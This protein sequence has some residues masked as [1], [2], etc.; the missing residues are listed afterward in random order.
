MHTV[1]LGCEKQLS[2]A[3]SWTQ[4]ILVLPANQTRETCT[5]F[6]F[7]PLYYQACFLSGEMHPCEQDLKA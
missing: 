3:T 1:L 4:W 6:V 2:P 5:G 7:V